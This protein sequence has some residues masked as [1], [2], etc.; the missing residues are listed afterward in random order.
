MLMAREA[1]PL[2]FDS[3]VSCAEDPHPPHPRPEQKGRVL[4]P[5]VRDLQWLSPRLLPC[6]NDNVLN[7]PML[8]SD[9]LLRWH[10]QGNCRCIHI[11]QSQS[12]VTAIVALVELQAR[13]EAKELPRV[14]AAQ[15]L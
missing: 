11:A 10:I 8:V 2:R 9:L 3:D 7:D 4:A 15:A 13:M 5:V 12:G 6:E 1:A 14:V